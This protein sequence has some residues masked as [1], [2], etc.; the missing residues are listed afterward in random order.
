MLTRVVRV[1]G[2]KKT[3]DDGGGKDASLPAANA[4]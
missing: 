2:V 4:A 1:E 3:G